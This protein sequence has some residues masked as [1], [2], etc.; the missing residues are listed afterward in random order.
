MLSIIAFHIISQSNAL[1]EENSN[2]FIF[3]VIFHGGGRLA[4]NVFIMIGAYFLVD[5]PFRMERILQLYLKVLI[6]CALTTMFM[7]FVAPEVCIN[8]GREVIIKQFFPISG[9][10]YWFVSTYIF[11]LIL[12]PILNLIISNK[13]TLAYQKTLMILS[14]ILMCIGSIPFFYNDSVFSNDLTW[15]VFLYIFIGLIKKHPIK[16]LSSKLFCFIGAFGAYFIMCA[17]TIIFNNIKGDWAYAWEIRFFYISHYQTV[18]AFLCALFTFSL[19]LQFDFS[20]KKIDWVAKHTFG[21]YLLHQVPI[22]YVTGWLWNDVFII[23][24]YF[25]SITFIPYSFGILLTVFILCTLADSILDVVVKEIMS[26]SIVIRFCAR[27]NK[28][29]Y[30]SLLKSSSSGG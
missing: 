19:F 5:L 17:T 30:I 8:I 12:T 15:F 22:I 1:G 6:V 3:S 2:N 20:N 18:F 10:P 16:L 14:L 27:I 9:N 4:C 24:K 28:K 7:L 21:V 13:E 23:N 29:V 25:N 11:M 26:I